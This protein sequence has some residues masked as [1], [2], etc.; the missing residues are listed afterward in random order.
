MF[1]LEFGGDIQWINIWNAVNINATD[2]LAI[3]SDNLGNSYT[4]DYCCVDLQA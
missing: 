3:D 4:L 1:V 2:I